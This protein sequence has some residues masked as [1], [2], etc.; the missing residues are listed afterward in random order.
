M[1][2]WTAAGKRGGCRSAQ[3]AQHHD[4]VSTQQAGARG[5][6]APELEE[7]IPQGSCTGH[8]LAWQGMQVPEDSATVPSEARKASGTLT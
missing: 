4:L 2:Q 8:D 5:L 6:R 1:V 3:N 7:A